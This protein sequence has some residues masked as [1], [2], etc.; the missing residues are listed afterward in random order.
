MRHGMITIVGDCDGSV[1]AELNDGESVRRSGFCNEGVLVVRGDG[2]DDG[3]VA[4]NGAIAAL[5][6]CDGLLGVI[7]WEVESVGNREL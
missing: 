3:I 1:K 2:A 4:E 5:G 6:D 7:V